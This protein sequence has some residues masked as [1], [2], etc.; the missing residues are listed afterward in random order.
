VEATGLSPDPK[1]YRTRLAD[2]PDDQLDAWAQELL[3]DMVI[4]HGIVPVVD[5]FRGATHLSEPEFERVFASGGGPPASVGRDAGGQLI[6]PAITL[7]ALIP[8]LRTQVTDART[9]I[10]DYLV[11]NFDEFV[12]V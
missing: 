9:R 2:Q 8:G 4:R 10:I 11:E 7:W 6:V 5:G 12:Y 1:E 3:R